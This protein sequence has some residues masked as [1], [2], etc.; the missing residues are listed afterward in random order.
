MLRSRV[1]FPVEAFVKRQLYKA[2]FCSGGMADISKL[3]EQYAS[4][5]GKYKL[6]SFEA[7]NADFDIDKIEQDST[8]VLRSVR[9]AVLEKV[10]NTLSFFEM[11]L[12]PANAP[13]MYFSYL[14]TMPVEDKAILEKLYNSFGS[15]VLAALPLEAG[16]DE[17]A[18]AAMIVRSSQVWHDAKKDLTTL[19]QHV[20]NPVSAQKKKE[21]S[22]FG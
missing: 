15:L 11:L 21:K 5:V 22:Y 13:R 2:F 10:F 14:K 16:Y 4:F 17:K 7:L 9:K 19:F 6:P 3:K 1:Q 12:N 18:E 20:A 8:L